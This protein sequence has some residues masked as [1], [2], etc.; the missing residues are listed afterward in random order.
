MLTSGLVLTSPAAARMGSL[1][2]AGSLGNAK[3]ADLKCG[4]TL[5]RPNSRR[6]SISVTTTWYAGHCNRYLFA[7]AAIAASRVC[8]QPCVAVPP[9]RRVRWLRWPSGGWGGFGGI[10]GDGLKVHTDGALPR[11]Q[12]PQNF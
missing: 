5:L 11:S 2:S 8:S 12:A 1:S 7:N 4:T 10:G 9:M 6:L 3:K